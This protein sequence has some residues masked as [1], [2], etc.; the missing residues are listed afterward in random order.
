MKI[1][2]IFHGTAGFP[3]EDWFPRLKGKL[4]KRGYQVFVP[5]FPTPVNK[6]AGYTGFPQLLEKLDHILE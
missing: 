3:E 6:S 4:E 1:A 2:F 5:Q